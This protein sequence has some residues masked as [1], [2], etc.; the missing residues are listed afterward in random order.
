M[1]SI[2]GYLGSR[3]GWNS[4]SLSISPY[5]SLFCHS[6]YFLRGL[7]GYGS[8]YLIDLGR[9]ENCRNRISNDFFFFLLSTA[10]H[11]FLMAFSSV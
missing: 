7:R 3:Q 4:G 9:K 11:L 8:G 6:M 10:L 1:H 2:P 5:I